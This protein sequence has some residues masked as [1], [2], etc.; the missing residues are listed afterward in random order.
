MT[1]PANEG[2]SHSE[3][4]TAARLTVSLTPGAGSRPLP[5]LTIN[6]FLD[7]S[8]A[9]QFSRAVRDAAANQ[10]IIVDLTQ[11]EFV[12]SAGISVLFERRD[13][14]AAVLVVAGSIIDLALSAARFPTIST[15]ATRNPR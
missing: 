6:G 11:A 4:L 2:I 13:S 1:A 8:T 3:G 9:S 5:K 14:F 15:H 7:I 12:G 10:K